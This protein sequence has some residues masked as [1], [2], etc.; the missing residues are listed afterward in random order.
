M[1][2]AV[3]FDLDGVLIDS[4]TSI[5]N[6][7]NHA[8]EQLGRPRRTR[9]ELKRFVG[10]Q[11]EGTAATL[12]AT[13]DP[14]LIARWVTAYRQRY[15]VTCV[16]ETE[17][18]AGLVDVLERLA[19]HVPL[20]VATA[21]PEVY[22]ERLLKAFGAWPH[23]R[24]LAGRSLAL[25]HETKAQI[26]ARALAHL[27]LPAGPDVVMVGDREHDVL[28]AQHHGIPTIGVL[29][30]AGDEA[31]LRAAGARWIA[32]DLREAARILEGLL[33]GPRQAPPP[34]HRARP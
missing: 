25:D 17:P 15:D 10:P 21:K 5:T 29:H 11:I 16:E 20:A 3:L 33:G 31:E 8:L 2:R 30:G 34:P 13:R 14:A 9:D 26:I 19:R 27:D 12:L 32:A 6:S 23:L 7:M 22:A 4:V 18:A 1:L 28:G 24:A